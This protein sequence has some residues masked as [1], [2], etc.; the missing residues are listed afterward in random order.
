M[1]YPV[2]WQTRDRIEMLNYS[3]T[4]ILLLFTT[5]LVVGCGQ[6]GALYIAES[7]AAHNDGHFM[8]SYKKDEN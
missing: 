6:T 2:S 3:K 7:E 1:A 8:T 5:F 4:F